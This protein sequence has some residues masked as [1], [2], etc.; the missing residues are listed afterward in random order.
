MKSFSYTLLLLMSILSLSCKK[1][2]SSPE[3][4]FPYY[5][6]ATVDN[7]PVKYEAN[8]KGSEYIC[9]T[10]QQGLGVSSAWDWY[11]G[12]EIYYQHD[13]TKN[14]IYI[15]LM[16]RYSSY[17]VLNDRLMTWQ[18]GD[19][20]YGVSNIRGGNATINGAVIIY[21]DEND[22]LWETEGGPQTGSSFKVTELVNS[23]AATFL[24]IFTAEFNCTLYSPSGKSIKMENGIVRGKIYR[25]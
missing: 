8:D 10:N 6:T 20:P 2:K 22:H 1:G 19:Y 15:Y 7:K 21:Y 14:R 3:T 18:L 9:W 5:F 17:P 16:R 23:E 4:K 12:T 13:Q 24:K 11:D 25:P